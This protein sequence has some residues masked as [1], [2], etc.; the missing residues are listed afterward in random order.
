MAGGFNWGLDQP[1][2]EF[3]EYDPDQDQWTERATCPATARYGTIGFSIG[4]K[5]YLGGGPTNIAYHF[6]SDF[7]EYDPGYNDWTQVADLPAAARGF[8]PGLNVGGSGYVGTGLI[9]N[10]TYAGDFWEFT[11]ASVGM[12]ESDHDAGVSVFPQ[13]CSSHVTVNIVSRAPNDPFT[14]L[15]VT[16]ALGRAV[17]Q[18]PISGSRIDLAT[19]DLMPGTYQ[20]RLSSAN[21]PLSWVK[22][23]IVL[24]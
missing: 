21:G 20:L 2:N 9:G 6:A 10:K 24:R 13:P 11:P 15:E 16:D 12:E 19:S 23:L 22:K 7:W 3:W 14:S 5:G 8:A 4:N 1:I 17:L 18:V